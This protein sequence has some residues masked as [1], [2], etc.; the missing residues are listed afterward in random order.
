MMFL[1]SPIDLANEKTH[2]LTH[3]NQVKRD[4]VHRYVVKLNDVVRATQ[5][6]IC[7]V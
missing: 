3:P 1:R 4:L 7:C 6:E 2:S 5:K